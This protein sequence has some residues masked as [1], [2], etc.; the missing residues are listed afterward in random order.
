[1]N[2]QIL[3]AAVGSAKAGG[4]APL[5]FTNT[6]DSE[7]TIAFNDVKSNGT[8]LSIRKSNKKPFDSWDLSAVSLQ[9]GEYIEVVGDTTKA[10]NFIGRFIMTGTIA[11]SGSIMSII[12]GESLTKEQ[13]L[14]MPHNKLVFYQG[15]TD[16]IFNGCTSL[17]AAPELPATTLTDNCYN[18]MFKGCTSLTAA[19]EL[20]ATTLNAYCYHSMFMG[21]T[22][23]TAAPELPATT[24]ANSCYGSIFNGCTSLTAV[25]VAFTNWNGDGYSTSIWLENV[26]ATG[27]FTCPVG[28]DT[29]ARDDSHVPDGWTVKNF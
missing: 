8:Q 26:A 4:L 17:T 12:Y 3:G 14:I 16:S 20:P 7:A 18:N 27:T 15:S 10:T 6:G 23:L 9:P 2:L 5:R 25:S 24:L 22:S 19:P 13:N 1:M 28:L 29:T 11:A 21:C